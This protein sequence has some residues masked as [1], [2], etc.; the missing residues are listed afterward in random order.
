MFPIRVSIHLVSHFQ[1]SYTHNYISTE[2]LISY[3]REDHIH[4]QNYPLE[5]YITFTWHGYLELQ[6]RHG[7]KVVVEASVEACSCMAS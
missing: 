6:V 1:T 3:E 4:M 2:A 5:C 7:T